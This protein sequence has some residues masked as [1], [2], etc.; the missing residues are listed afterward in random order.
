MKSKYI[1]IIALI[2]AIVTTVLFRQYIV[3]LDNKYKKANQIVT[4]VVPK[5]DI[6][7]NQKV[8][9]EMIELKEMSGSAVHPQALK[10]I[11][12]V[13]GK[14]ATTDL[15]AGEILF[16]S[17]FTD[18]FT[19]NQVITRKI[20]DGFRAVSIGVNDI[21]AVTKMIQ[22]E[23]YVDVIFTIN[24][25]TNIIL[26]NVR[27]LAVG[28][29]LTETDPASTDKNAAQTADYGTVT[30]EL[31]PADIVKVINADETG[32]VKF[33]LRGKLTP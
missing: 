2:M 25:Q 8:T 32:S 19:E 23:D 9:K 16:A 14:Y 20:Q 13:E 18:M 21:S 1:L 4:V 11:S 29:R 5:V 24:G 17:R 22:P 12:D 30:L 33:V 3:S 7:E 15:K 28:K 31:Y 6:K 27:V 26:E 10:K